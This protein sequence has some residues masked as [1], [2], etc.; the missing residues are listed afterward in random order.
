MDHFQYCKI[1]NIRISDHNYDDLG[2]LFPKDDEEWDDY[3]NVSATQCFLKYLEY[4]ESAETPIDLKQAAVIV[5]SHLDRLSIPHQPA[6]EQNVFYATVA[7]P[8]E[9]HWLGQVRR[10]YVLLLHRTP[11]KFC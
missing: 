1:A 10:L 9:V 4:P 6:L 5:M 11:S 7:E 2:H 3:E 8:Q